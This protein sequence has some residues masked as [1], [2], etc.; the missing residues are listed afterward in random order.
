MLIAIVVLN[1]SGGTSEFSI[2]EH[3]KRSHGVSNQATYKLVLRT[4]DAVETEYA[5]SD[6]DGCERS[7][8]IGQSSDD[9]ESILK[10]RPYEGRLYTSM[11]LFSR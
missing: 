6:V 9:G 1:F 11:R 2:T 4:Y 7:I 8:R 3:L 5:R 10:M